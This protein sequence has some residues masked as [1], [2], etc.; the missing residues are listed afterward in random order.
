MSKNHRIATESQSLREKVKWQ[1][2]TS[3]NGMSPT[4][5]KMCS[6]IKHKKCCTD[7]NEVLIQFHLVN[8]YFFCTQVW[9]LPRETLNAAKPPREPWFCSVKSSLYSAGH[10]KD[11]CS[12][13]VSLNPCQYVHAHTNAKAGTHA[14]SQKH[15]HRYK[16]KD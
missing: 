10:I 2:K 7:W 5:I 3:S 1:E 12:E 14:D 4:D 16:D 8:Q 9:P 13:N 11:R 15:M 6:Q